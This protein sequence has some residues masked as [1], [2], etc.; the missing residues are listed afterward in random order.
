[1]QLYTVIYDCMYNIFHSLDK[2]NAQFSSDCELDLSP[3]FRVF[4][5]MSLCKAIELLDELTIELKSLE[6][7]AKHPIFEIAE[8]NTR[9]ARERK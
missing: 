6:F 1:M 7:F 3:T 2:S 5:V 9:G 8:R 4:H